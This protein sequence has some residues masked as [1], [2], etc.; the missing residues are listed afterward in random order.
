MKSPEFRML[1][2]P[3]PAEST[4]LDVPYDSAAPNVVLTRDLVEAPRQYDL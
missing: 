2:I 3:E 1:T 4:R